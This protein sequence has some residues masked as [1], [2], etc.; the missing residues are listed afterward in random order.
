MLI[1]LNEID[2]KF[3]F[4]DRFGRVEDTHKLQRFQIFPGIILYN[5]GMTSVL[6]M[7]NREG[8]ESILRF[9]QCYDCLLYTSDAADE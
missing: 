3:D 8:Q 2:E 1:G 5:L 9:D 4:I 7:L 6:V